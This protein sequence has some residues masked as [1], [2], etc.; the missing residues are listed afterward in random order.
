MNAVLSIEGMT[1]AHCVARVSNALSKVAGVN[2]VKVDLGRNQ[3]TLQ[4]ENLVEHD[5][6]AA[7][8]D[9]GYVAKVIQRA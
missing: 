6:E 2:K 8:Q 7:V 1:C 4:G 9:A 3:A 5:L